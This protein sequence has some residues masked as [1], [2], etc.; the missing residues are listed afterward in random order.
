MIA[1]EERRQSIKGPKLVGLIIAAPFIGLF[2]FLLLPI[3]TVCMV[4]FTTGIRIWKGLKD[5]IAMLI[6][7]EWKPK[8]A[9]LKGKKIKGGKK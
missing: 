8:V 9:Y 1:Y 6:S 7:F 5:L 4:L 2:Y 3:I